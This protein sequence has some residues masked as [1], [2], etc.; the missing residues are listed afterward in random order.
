M[1]T[2]SLHACRARAGR[3]ERCQ[4]NQRGGRTSGLRYPSSMLF[5]CFLTA[6][7]GRGEGACPRG[8]LMNDVLTAS[9]SVNPPRRGGLSSVLRSAIITRI[10]TLA[11]AMASELGLMGWSWTCTVRRLAGRRRGRGALHSW[12]HQPLSQRDTAFC[13]APSQMFHATRR[14]E[15]CRERGRSLGV[16]MLVFVLALASPVSTRARPFLFCIIGVFCILKGCACFFAWMHTPLY[17][18]ACRNHAGPFPSFQP[19]VLSSASA[20]VTSHLTTH[21]RASGFRSAAA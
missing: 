21:I 1:H 17:P 12:A 8:S 16:L 4:N 3:E 9:S 10:Y 7:E 15:A 11:P 5:P 19:V 18:W 20:P 2:A 14:V 13:I 6:L